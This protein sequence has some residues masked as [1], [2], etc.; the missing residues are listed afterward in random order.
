MCAASPRSASM[1]AAAEVEVVDTDDLLKYVLPLIDACPL[2]SAQMQAGAVDREM[3]IIMA[4]SERNSRDFATFASQVSAGLRPD[5]RMQL[6]LGRGLCVSAERIKNAYA[7]MESAIDF[8]ALETYYLMEARAKRIGLAS[9][10]TLH[11]LLDWQG[12]SLTAEAE[13]MLAPEPPDELDLTA[14]SQAGST[15][16]PQVQ[17]SVPHIWPFTEGFQSGSQQLRPEY[18]QLVDDHAKA[19]SLGESYGKFD[20]AGK[21]FYL[22]KMTEIRTRW[23]DLFLA[24]KQRGLKPSRIYRDFSREYRE[25]NKLSP[26]SFKNLVADVHDR[27]RRRTLAESPAES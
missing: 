18:E 26:A 19:V 10:H 17:P 27:I 5:P 12:A 20:Q 8:Q 7:K 21:E 4:E 16:Q 15:G 9:P 1:A 14:I 2:R 6:N 11:L 25:Y 3:T 24:A 23:Q 22:D 13:G